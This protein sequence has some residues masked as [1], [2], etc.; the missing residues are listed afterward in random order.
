MTPTTTSTV[1]AISPRHFTCGYR[2]AVSLP[3]RDAESGRDRRQTKDCPPPQRETLGASTPLATTAIDS[4][5]SR[6]V[7]VHKI[8]SDRVTA[9]QRRQHRTQCGG[10][11][12]GP[13]DDLADVFCF[14][15]ICQHP[16]STLFPYT[17]FLPLT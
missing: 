2:G 4:A 6:S 14:D 12:A 15:M 1:S 7:H 17:P 3:S 8:D 11:S 13:A 5:A 9:G 10:R 16:A